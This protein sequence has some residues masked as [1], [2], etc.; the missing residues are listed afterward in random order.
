MSH[1]L[2]DFWASTANP[3]ISEAVLLVDIDAD[4]AE[5]KDEIRDVLQLQKDKEEGSEIWVFQ[6]WQLGIRVV[7]IDDTEAPTLILLLIIW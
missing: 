6:R 1:G 7:A 5:A 4:G 3:S 2:L